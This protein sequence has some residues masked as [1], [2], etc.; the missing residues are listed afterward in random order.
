MRF[1]KPAFFL[2]I[3][4]ALVA[5][6][7]AVAW[8]SVVAGS[9][10]LVLAPLIVV[11]IHDLVQT[12][13]A[14]LRN[15]PLLGHVRYV[16]ESLAP[17]IQQYFI[18]RHTDGTPISRNHRNLVY[19]RS[20][21][22]AP[23]HPFGTEHELYANAYRGL[24]HS[25]Y[26]VPPLRDAPRVTIGGEQC[27]QPYAASLINISAMSYG[28]LGPTAVRALAANDALPAKVRKLVET[29]N[30]SAAKEKSPTSRAWA[31][32]AI[33]DRCYEALDDGS[34]RVAAH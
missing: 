5:A 12:K 2:L 30:D 20:R 24:A 22:E 19:A 23:T 26:P 18:E 3:A 25:I 31:L 28:A 33:L 27:K 1:V 29:R 11:G 10:A 14:I 16:A 8:S 21:G 15:F 17:E 13:N 9:I 34:R 32:R 7:L 6:V 4:G